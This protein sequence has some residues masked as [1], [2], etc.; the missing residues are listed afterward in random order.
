MGLGPHGTSLLQ[1]VG[2]PTEPPGAFELSIEQSNRTEARKEAR[3]RYARKHKA[4]VKPMA[5]VEE[6]NVK[7]MS[8]KERWWRWIGENITSQGIETLSYYTGKQIRKAGFKL[9]RLQKKG[10]KE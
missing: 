7:D 9:P 10:R 1:R 5:P 3:I 8:T 4:K 6:T 2:R